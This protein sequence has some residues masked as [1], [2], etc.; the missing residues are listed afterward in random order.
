[1]A[2]TK[3]IYNSEPLDVV[4]EMIRRSYGI[5]LDLTYCSVAVVAQ[6]STV[7]QVSI[8]PKT[9][10]GFS[11][12]VDPV[13]FTINK[14]N[15]VARL[16]KDMCY[17]GNW[18]ATTADFA[19][20]INNGYGLLIKSGQW[21]VVHNGVVYPLNDA[22]VID[23]DISDDRTITLRPTAAHPLFVPAMVFSMLVTD[24][25]E[26]VQPLTMTVAGDGD[27]DVGSTSQVMFRT[28]GGVGKLTYEILEGEL[29]LPLADDGTGLEGSYPI[30]GMFVATVGVRDS[31]GQSAQGDVLLN[32]QMG[33][34]HSSNSA[35]QLEAGESYNFDYDLHGGFPPLRI[36]RTDYL[37]AGATL[38]ETGELTGRLDPGT[39]P[40]DF[41]VQDKLGVRTKL[42]DHLVVEARNPGVAVGEAEL[43]VV[44]RL[45]ALST[46]ADGW[47]VSVDSQRGPG[48]ASWQFVKGHLTRQFAQEFPAFTL[49]MW[50]QAGQSQPGA[51]IYSQR[52][53]NNA[54]EIFTGDYDHHQ[55]RVLLTI[56]GEQYGVMSDALK[57]VFAETDT[58][59][60]VTIGEGLLALYINGQ[61]ETWTTTPV[62][63]KILPANSTAYLGR[64]PEGLRQWNG[65]ISYLSLH[66][67][68]LL[69]DQFQ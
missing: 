40:F 15:L 35:P 33:F 65:S 61:L 66:K 63:A 31:L 42:S 24:P 51:C 28:T 46:L 50:A 60:S 52:S 53:G 23:P 8:T 29:P 9:V 58:M 48:T 2:G 57:G 44:H 5:A 12:Y 21:E 69:N 68:R 64:D 55:I 18:P 32:V 37:P 22:A 39:Y 4:I 62:F 17:S 1:M 11:L 26:V 3:N 34:V 36:V 45:S 10:N 67:A 7:S 27:V 14:L 20:F 47:Q 43:S 56:N 38:T 49:T 25:Q 13:N 41:I 59:I 16:P 54:V 19:T 6:S 30:T